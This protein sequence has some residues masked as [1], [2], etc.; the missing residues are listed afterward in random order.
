MKKLLFLSVLTIAMGARCIA[1]NHEAVD[2]GLSVNWAACN[3]GAMSPTDAGGLYGWGDVTGINH[4]ENL[5]EYPTANPPSSICGTEYDIASKMWGNDWRIPSQDE[6][7][8]LVENCTWEWTTIDGING[9]KVTGK[10][11]NHIF[12]PAAATRT[13]DTVSGMVG[14][15]GDYWSGTLWPSDNKFASY[16][17]F[18]DNADNVQ[19]SRSNRRYIG[20]SIRPVMSPNSGINI[21][22]ADNVYNG[23]TETYNLNGQRVIHTENLKG[24]Y[25][26][27]NSGKTNKV[28]F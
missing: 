19:P 18:Y 25:I 6:M 11:G 16:L 10:N 8:E 23:V 2:L 14:K 27:K 13:G 20:M 28:V 21:I 26:V 24:I 17:Y 5:D 1:Q 12:L 3:V 4:S 22:S 9:M 15:R 7:V